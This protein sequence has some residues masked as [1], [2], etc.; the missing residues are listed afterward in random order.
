MPKVEVKEIPAASHGMNFQN[1][2]A[3]DAAII[4]FV[5]RHP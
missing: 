3:L 1:P 5:E 4:D 2:E